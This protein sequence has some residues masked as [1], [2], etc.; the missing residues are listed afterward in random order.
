M[1][2]RGQHRSIRERCKTGRELTIDDVF[3]TVVIDINWST[4]CTGG[5][6]PS[7]LFVTTLGY[8]IIYDWCAHVRSYVLSYGHTMS[9][10][11]SNY[12]H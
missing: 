2:V 8:A 12:R 10:K 9:L 4:I 3:H 1:N 7:T 5:L 11:S 6:P